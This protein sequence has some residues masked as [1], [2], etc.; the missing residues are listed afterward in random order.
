MSAP[1]KRSVGLLAAALCAA[2]V[3]RADSPASFWRIAT[4]DTRVSWAVAPDGAKTFLRG[5]DH[6]NWNGHWCEAL[7]TNPYRD[8]MAKKFAGDQAAW[9]EE[10][11]SRLK[12][13]G[14]NML[15][16]GCS[17]ELENRGLAHTVFLSMGHGFCRRGPEFEISHFQEIP[18]TG[19]PNVFHPDWE[20]FC[21][22]RA[23]KLCEPRKENRDLFGYFFDNE[24][25][26]RG[27]TTAAEGM[28]NAALQLPPEHTAR[29]TAEKVAGE[30]AA[31]DAPVA[32]L[33][34][35]AARYFGTIAEA[36]RRHDG[37]HLLL[38]CRFAGIWAHR[39]VWKEAGRVCDVLTFN[40]YPW[41]DLDRNLVFTSRTS[42]R[43]FVEAISER[44]DWAKKPFV[45]TEWSFPALDA[46]LPCSG[47][48][49]QRFRTQAER[50]QAT[51]LF[52]RTLLAL[53]FMIG[54]DYFMWVDEPALG[55]SGNFPEDS[56]YGLVNERGEPYAELTAMFT[57]LHHDAEALHK[58]PLPAER[59]APE[60]AEPPRTADEALAKLGKISG[61][62]SPVVVDA[63][64]GAY[65]LRTPT[66][67]VLSGRIGG[68]CMLDS[69]VLGGVDYGPFTA[70]LFHGDW[71]NIDRVMSAEWL[72]ER[73]ALR[74]A[75]E[76][77]DGAKAFRI[78]CDITP[79]GELSGAL[80]NR[81]ISGGGALG[82]RALPVGADR[83]AARSESAAPPSTF[84]VNVV[85]VD[86]IGEAPLANG[87]VFLRQNPPWAADKLAGGFRF[88]PNVWKAPDADLWA[89]T[90]D[91]AWCGAATFSPCVQ[92]FRYWVSL[93]DKAAHPDAAFSPSG[94][95]VLSPGESYDP[96]GRMWYVAAYGTG[97][98]A[99]W[100]RFL[101]A[102]PRESTP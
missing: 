7:K 78:T 101:D 21:D 99:G 8:E 13:W 12:A 77:R 14:F 28:Y 93:P 16:A 26:W 90:S 9:Q 35:C 2:A 57:R 48:A 92:H 17:K 68:K 55:I 63:D 18:G 52:A 56:N 32:F 38:G 36:I 85:R 89:R 29:Q 96:P 60:G 24:L 66:G 61:A 4:D 100:R 27:R 58:A 47:G 41:A 91:G 86:N 95:I 10:T 62:V 67:L 23:A 98:E 72:P 70:M 22:E 11:L 73:E 65:T 53:P 1:M 74:I 51:E 49:G 46:G 5:I 37:N 84:L 20:R 3:A 25:D 79:V 19:F 50:T 43:R 44:H 80:G 6:A 59:P 34:L 88:A 30:A 83:W 82:D 97:G 75:G 64:T 15:G 45:I 69:I 94:G 42:G 33:R 54:Y 76:L 102:L 81:A 87:S 31:I 40:C 71:Q 39:V